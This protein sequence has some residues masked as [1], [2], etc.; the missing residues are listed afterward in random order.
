MDIL[1]IAIDLIGPKL[2]LGDSLDSGA[3]GSALSGLMGGGDG[4]IDVA[5]LISKFQGG[6]LGS[7]VG[8]FMGD[9]ENAPMSAENITEIFGADKVSNFA[10]EVGVETSTAA[11]ALSDAVPELINQVSS[12]GNLLEGLAGDSGGLLGSLKK[13]F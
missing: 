7:L 2:G 11:S 13:L 8:S 3:L 1:K 12:G 6:D 9:G 4:N 5:G 10:S